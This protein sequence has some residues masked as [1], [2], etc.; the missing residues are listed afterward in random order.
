LQPCDLS[1]NP[2]FLNWIYFTLAFFF[3]DVIIYFLNLDM[4][5]YVAAFMLWYRWAY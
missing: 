4:S 2:V 5:G 3:M 1:P